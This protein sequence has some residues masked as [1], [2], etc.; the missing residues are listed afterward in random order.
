MVLTGHVFGRS[1][2]LVDPIYGLEPSTIT[3]VTCHLAIAPPSLVRAHNQPDPDC[4]AQGLS[5]S[6]L[7]CISSHRSPKQRRFARFC[8]QLNDSAKPSNIRFRVMLCKR[9][10]VVAEKGVAIL[11]SDALRSQPVSKRVP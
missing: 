4:I 8:D 7:L 10:V 5:L 9:S 11:R 1:F 6:N 2:N 3:C